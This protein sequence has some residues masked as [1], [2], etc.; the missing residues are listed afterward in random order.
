M[1][2]NTQ[3]TLQEAAYVA[4]RAVITLRLWVASG[5][6]KVVPKQPGDTRTHVFV[7]D[8]LEALEKPI[9]SRRSK[10]GRQRKGRFKQTARWYV[11]HLERMRLRRLLESPSESARRL[12]AHASYC[13][14]HYDPAARRAKYLRQKAK[15]NGRA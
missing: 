2:P 4:Q 3:L 5:F 7:G 6:L 10:S 12:A 14:K 15:L 9:R 1:D 13:R 11:R 8:L